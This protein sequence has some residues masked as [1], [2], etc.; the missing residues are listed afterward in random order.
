MNERPQ[1]PAWFYWFFAGY[2]VLMLIP[3]GYLVFDFITH[4][5]A[6]EAAYGSVAYRLFTALVVVPICLIGSIMVLRR[7]PRNVIG[8]FLLSLAV[9]SMVATV[10]W[11]APMSIENFNFM[12]SALWLLPLFFPDGQPSPKRFGNWVRLLA[13]AY[14]TVILLDTVASPTAVLVRIQQVGE[15]ANPLFIPGLLPLKDLLDNLAAVSWSTL[16]IVIVPSLALRYRSSDYAVRQQI[17]WFIWVYGL[18]IIMIVA[19]MFAQDHFGFDGQSGIGLAINV[20]IQIFFQLAPLIVVANA[21]LRHR[22]YDIDI[23]IRRTLVYS[24][25]T[26]VLAAIYFGGVVLAQQVF[27]AASGQSSDPAIVASTLLIAALFTPLRRRIQQIIDRRFYRR[28]YDAEQT[29]A[30]FNQTLRDEVDMET[31]QQHLIGVV[32]DT[33]QPDRMA[34]WISSDVPNS[35]EVGVS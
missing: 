23:I 5:L 13:I 4:P 8:L 14:T 17:K 2:S 24:I 22:L 27:R 20:A 18:I 32:H 28:K 6:P 7:V 15:I 9:Y 35:P 19:T 25:L 12:G 33:M 30:R 1:Q 21:I 3:F 11:D 29:L 31:L 16:M 26:A 34:L 10:R